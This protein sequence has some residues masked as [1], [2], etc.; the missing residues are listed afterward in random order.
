MAVGA[1]LFK[2]R[3]IAWLYP[4]KLT[5]SAGMSPP[6]IDKIPDVRWYSTGTIL[7]SPATSFVDLYFLRL[8][9]QNIGKSKAE[10]VQ[11]FAAQLHRRIADDTFAPVES[12]LPM[13]LR[14]AFGSENPSHAETFAETILPEMGVHCN[15]ARVA[16]PKYRKQIGDDNRDAELG[17]TVL[18]L[19]T[20]LRPTNY[21]NVLKP[22][23]YRL[24]L[25]VAGAN[26]KP[27]SWIVELALTGKW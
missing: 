14:W 13:N 27:T 25:L 26:C 16:D 4:P 5:V 1:A 15:L 12:F 19:Q 22:G 9:I 23:F 18:A 21:S 17:E 20:E 11:V 2:E 8:W 24:K 7:T 10:K 6:D 3:I